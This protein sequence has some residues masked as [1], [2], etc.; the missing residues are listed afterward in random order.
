MDGWTNDGWTIDRWTT[1]SR[2]WHKLTWSKAHKWSKLCCKFAEKGKI[3]WN[4]NTITLSCRGEKT[5]SKIEEICQVAVSNQITIISMQISNLVKIH[6]IY[7]KIWMCCR[8]ITLSKIDKICPLAIQN[9]ISTISMH[10]PSWVK[11]HWYLLKLSSRK[12]ITDMSQTDDS[13]KNWS[14][15]PISYYPKPDLFNIS[16]HNK[17]GEKIHWHLLKLSSG[18]E[19][20]V[21]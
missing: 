17:F 8:Q 16:A 11:I 20:E 21:F 18:H 19:N 3:T 12:E 7:S 1:D 14:N 2:P 6:E 15:L 9:Q 5:L 13:V 10:I 4:H